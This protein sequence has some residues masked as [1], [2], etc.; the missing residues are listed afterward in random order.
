V[1][2]DRHLI[3]STPVV[4]ELALENRRELIRSH[5]ALILDGLGSYN[6]KLSIQAY[7][8]LRDWLANYRQVARTRATII[9]QR[10]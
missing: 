2:A 4:P 3:D 9:Y 5:P 6:P 8:D 7:P 10:R 1:P